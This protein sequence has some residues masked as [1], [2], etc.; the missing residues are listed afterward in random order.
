MIPY[1]IIIFN[2]YFCDVI[3]N[4]S[5]YINTKVSFNKNKKP[6]KFLLCPSLQK[7]DTIFIVVSC[8]F[9]IERKANMIATATIFFCDISG[10]LQGK[11]ENKTKDYEMFNNLILKIKEQNHSD[12]LF[13]SLLS[14]DNAESVKCQSSYLNKY[15]S[16]AISTQKQFFDHGYID[17]GNHVIT[18]IS[19][20]CE[21]MVYYLNELSSTYY[22]DKIILADDLEIFHEMMTA[23][24]EGFIWK[25]KIL[26]IIPTKNRGLDELNDLLIHQLQQ[27]NQCILQKI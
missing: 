3:C 7:Y 9:Y 12:Y 4:G 20:K 26:S 18:G 15:F 25:D 23:I 2:I 14:S 10:T 11:S 1:L 24:S 13:F 27:E 5:D 17:D 22:I 19:R 21:Q 6:N 8:M 16:H